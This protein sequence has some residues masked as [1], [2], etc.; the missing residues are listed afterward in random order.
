MSLGDDVFEEIYED[1]YETVTGHHGE[2]SHSKTSPSIEV[3]YF[4]FLCK[5][6][7]DLSTCACTFRNKKTILLLQSSIKYNFPV[8]PLK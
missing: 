7:M 6:F 1:S 2:S 8:S 3:C 5:N 4:A